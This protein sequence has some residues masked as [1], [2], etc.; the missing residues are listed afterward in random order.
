MAPLSP[1]V[2]GSR[3]LLAALLLRGAPALAALPPAPLRLPEP[4][5]PPV[6]RVTIDAPP[7]AGSV[8][9]NRP[10][11]AVGAPMRLAL[12]GGARLGAGA[13]G[14]LQLLIDYNVRAAVGRS[15]WT[16]RGFV[17]AAVWTAFG[18]AYSHSA[19]ADRHGA[20]LGVGVG[21]HLLG[22]ERERATTTRSR[23]ALGWVPQVFLGRESGEFAVGLRNTLSLELF[24]QIVGVHAVH[25]Y[26]VVAGQA[27]QDVFG[28]LSFNPFWL[29]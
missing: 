20:V 10:R 24:R 28:L 17:S 26:T 13:E 9:Y 7:D 16:P 8:Y 3:L 27:S 25:Q 6:P 22:R 11:M 4:A 29:L 23:H 21:A 14:A 2:T 1:P 12:G 19:S 15:G 18:Y 5:P